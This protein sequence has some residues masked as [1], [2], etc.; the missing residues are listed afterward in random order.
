LIF[1]H[2]LFDIIFS[3]IFCQLYKYGPVKIAQFCLAG[4]IGLCPPFFIKEPPRKT[5]S[6]NLKYFERTPKELI[7]SILE[8]SI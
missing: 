4:S 6:L 7:N 2:A 5:M 3:Y 8:F 1:I